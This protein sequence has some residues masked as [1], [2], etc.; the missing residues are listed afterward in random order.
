MFEFNVF[1]NDSQKLFRDLYAKICVEYMI[2]GT[3]FEHAAPQ[4][5]FILSKINDNSKSDH[6]ITIRDWGIVDL[7]E[8][9]DDSLFLAKIKL[10]KICCLTIKSD[11]QKDGVAFI[12]Q[13]LNKEDVFIET[14]YGCPVK[15][16]DKIYETSLSGN[17]LVNYIQNQT[18]WDVRTEYP[19]T[20][21]LN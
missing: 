6:A 16:K 20:V 18:D 4:F 11:D 5:D 8:F 7:N 13:Y 15:I 10:S 17:M 19:V 14:N 2:I 12:K 21:I 9:D 1:T 3:M